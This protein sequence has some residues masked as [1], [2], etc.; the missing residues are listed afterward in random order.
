MM[1]F[2]VRGRSR[3]GVLAGLMALAVTASVAW[4]ATGQAEILALVNYETKSAESLKVLKRAIAPPDRKEGL[5]VID[6]DPESPSFGK[7]VKDMP[8]PGDAV[9]HHIFYNRDQ[10]KA[11]ITALGKP[12]L[13]VIDMADPNLSIKVVPVPDCLVGE[14]VIFSE[15]NK[16]WYLTCMGSNAVIV[17]DVATDAPTKTI[18]VPLK[19]PHGI[20]IHSGIDR[21]LTSSTVRASDLGDAGEAVGVLEAKSGKYLGEIKVS[22]KPSPSGAAPVE[23]LFVPDRKPPVAYVTNMYEGTLWA[24]TW[25]PGKKTFDPSQ[26]YDFSPIKAGVPLELYVTPDNKTLYVTTAK[27]GHLH[28]FDIAKD[29]RKPVLRTSIATAEGAHHVAFTRDWRYAFVQNALLNLPGMSDGSITVVDLKT[30]KVVKSV[31]TLKEAGYNPN[32]IVLLPKWNHL[33]GH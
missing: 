4:P 23:L 22:N 21:I 10:S 30:N 31:D 16:T 29:P 8:L 28:I 14:D 1:G 19:Y 33:A 6:V 18:S 7:I 2:G 32:S 25:N 15:D 20:A 13:R 5:A 24:L 9:I 26:A 3:S 27:P 11:Y 17:G 12:E